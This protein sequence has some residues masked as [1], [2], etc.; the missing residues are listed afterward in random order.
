MLLLD[1][2]KQQ[3]DMYGDINKLTG[4]EKRMRMANTPPSPGGAGKEID[5]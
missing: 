5:K 1:Y 3:E 4:G 2:L